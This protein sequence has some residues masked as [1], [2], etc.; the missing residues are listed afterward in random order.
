MGGFSGHRQKREKMYNTGK[1][2]DCIL[3]KSWAWEICDLSE[4]EI[5]VAKW[6]CVGRV[7][8]MKGL[9]VLM[10]NIFY[11]KISLVYIMFIQMKRL[12]ATFIIHD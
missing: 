8:M 12:Y 10:E 7:E 2:V 3:R 5:Y 11:K 6:Q 9:F 4:K 1:R